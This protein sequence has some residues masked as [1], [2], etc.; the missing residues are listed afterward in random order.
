MTLRRS[1]VECTV[2]GAHCFCSLNIDALG[3]L[4]KMGTE[5]RYKAGDRI[6]EEGAPAELICVVCKG[7]L[8][9]MT[10]S[11]DGRLL[12]LRIVGPGDVLGL[13]SALKGTVY[14]GTAEALELCEIR[15]ILRTD[16]L[17]FMEDFKGVGLNTAEA[18]AR[19]YGSAVLSARRLALSGSAAGKLANV[20]LDWGRMSARRGQPTVTAKTDADIRTKKS[21]VEAA[22]RFR[23][24]LTHEELGHM[25]GISRETATRVL[26]K[27][28]SE[29]LV[30]ME[31]E[32]MVLR[33]PERL[34][35]LYC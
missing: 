1:C 27:L 33:S 3:Q 15:V 23:M 29:G 18:V 31:G 14:E 28:K 10:S 13:A 9:L 24:P 30:E 7:T 4:D 35:Q 20:L 2:R 16:F 6:L 12:L 19:E 34:E 22:L 17:T 32:R 5:V 26:T 25:A 11:R 21:P 8:K